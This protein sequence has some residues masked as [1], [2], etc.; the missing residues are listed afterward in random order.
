MRELGI[1]GQHRRSVEEE[2][3][4]GEW[5]PT[6]SEIRVKGKKEKKERE[7]SG[8]LGRGKSEV[9]PPLRTLDPRA[10]EF[11][12]S[13][14]FSILFFSIHFLIYSHLSFEVKLS[15]DSF[16]QTKCTMTKSSA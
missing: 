2:V 5:D 10:R 4:P 14:F 11:F 12:F 16:I 8:L 3:P 7:G 15:L 9:G 6:I 13:I 1:P